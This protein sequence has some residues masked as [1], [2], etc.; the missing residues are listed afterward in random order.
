MAESSNLWVLLALALIFIS[1]LTALKHYLLRSETKRRCK[2]TDKKTKILNTSLRKTTL[3][4][5][6][7]FM[8]SFGA[9]CLGGAIPSIEPLRQ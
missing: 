6:Y 3:E 2:M 1:L 7:D 9:G 5:L 8:T 4:V